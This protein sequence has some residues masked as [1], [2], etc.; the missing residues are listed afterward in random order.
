MP[1][2]YI[3]KFYKYGPYHSAL[4][5]IL[6]LIFTLFKSGYQNIESEAINCQL[7]GVIAQFINQI[8]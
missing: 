3:L 8:D 6:D 5:E 4:Q 7:F 1:F 2:F